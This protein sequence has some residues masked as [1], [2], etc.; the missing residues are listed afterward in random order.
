MKKMRPTLALFILALAAA[1]ISMQA[2][3]KMMIKDGSN[4]SIYGTSNVHDWSEHVNEMHGNLVAVTDGSTLKS[5][6]ELSFDSKV[7]SIKSG[8]ETMDEYTYEALKY[9][10]HPNIRFKSSSV[11]VS[12]S[13]N[14][15]NSYVVTAKGTMKIAGF[16]KTEEIKANCTMAGTKL[17]CEGKKKID[18]TTYD[19]EPPSIMFGAMTVGKEVEVHFEAIYQ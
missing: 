8:K 17:T 16:D 5:I 13:S 11:Q 7:S 1:P 9:E 6:S 15:A 12:P 18:M 10:D 2:Q 14:G 3:Q 19:V 4:L